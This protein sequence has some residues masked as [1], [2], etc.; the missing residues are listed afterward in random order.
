MN[1][2]VLNH[3]DYEN[4][5]SDLDTNGKGFLIRRQQILVHVTRVT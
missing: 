5:V 3:P 1:V 4:R 2:R